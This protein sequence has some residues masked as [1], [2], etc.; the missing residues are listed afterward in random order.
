[1]KT[2]TK[3]TLNA[4]SNERIGSLAPAAVAEIS[5]NL[6]RLLADVFALYVKSKGFH[7]HMTGCHFRDSQLL[8]D[9][10]AA[11]IF[12][13]R[14]GFAER[15]RKIGGATLHSIADIAQHKTLMDVVD[16]FV[17]AHFQAI[18]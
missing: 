8:L 4:Y 2:A 16:W 9:E 15:A 14:D 17:E 18:N 13:M 12:A 10:Q 6:R 7:W 1:M 3:E 5:K 11:Q